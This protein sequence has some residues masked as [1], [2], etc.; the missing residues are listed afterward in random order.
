[1]KKQFAFFSTLALVGWCIY[2]D[3][4][5]P[6]ANGYGL[7]NKVIFN[8]NM[9]NEKTLKLANKILSHKKLPDVPQELVRDQIKI[10]TRDQQEITLS[11][12]K[13]ENKKELT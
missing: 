5:Y 9:I 10:K 13:E 2:R 11:I 4:K 1:M 7:F 12:Y 8:G 3:K 6:L